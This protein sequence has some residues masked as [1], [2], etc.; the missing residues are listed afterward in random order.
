MYNNR[1]RANKIDILECVLHICVYIGVVHSY[2]V[3]LTSQAVGG[4]ED[5]ALLQ[6]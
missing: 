1:M 3:C 5:V 6:G 2:I 4:R